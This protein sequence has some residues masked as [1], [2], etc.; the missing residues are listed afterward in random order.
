[1]GSASIGGIIGATLAGWVFDTMADYRFM[2][3]ALCTLSV[4]AVVLISRIRFINNV[5]SK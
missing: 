1:M 5:I 4:L 3:L 2:W